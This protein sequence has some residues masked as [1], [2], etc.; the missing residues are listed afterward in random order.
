MHSKRL[1]FVRGAA[2]VIVLGGLLAILY[3]N[4]R[5]QPQYTPTEIIP[6]GDQALADNAVAPDAPLPTV[7]KAPIPDRPD[8]LRFPET[9]EAEIEALFESL[10]QAC[11]NSDLRMA[12]LIR[13]E[14]LAIYSEPVYLG[15]ERRLKELRSGGEPRVGAVALTANLMYLIA[16]TD[17][18]PVLEWL[19]QRWR[20][21]ELSSILRR[22]W[23]RIKDVEEGALASDV[24]PPE[25]RLE[26]AAVGHILGRLIG[27]ADTSPSRVLELV[28]GLYGN[29]LPE[30]EVP[31]PW[32]SH[33]LTEAMRKNLALTDD[34]DSGMRSFLTDLATNYSLS[35]CLRAQASLYLAGRSQTFAELLRAIGSAGSKKVVGK[36]IGHFLT[37]HPMTEEEFALIFAALRDKYGDY[38]NDMTEV[39]RAILDN[40]AHAEAVDT[41]HLVTSHLLEYITNDTTEPGLQWSAH[42]FLEGL[43][44]VW[45]YFESRLGTPVVLFG[46][47]SERDLGAL[48]A[49]VYRRSR[50][51]TG[52]VAGPISGIF[53]ASRALHLVWAAP[54]PVEE[55]MDLTLDLLGDQPQISRPDFN[56]ALYGLRRSIDEL[57]VQHYSRV[58]TIIELLYS[59]CDDALPAELAK[60]QLSGVASCLAATAD[61]L[62]HCKFPEL[63]LEVR[64][65]I[66]RPIDEVLAA[67]S[68][69]EIYLNTSGREV[70]SLMFDN[71][72]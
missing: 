55:R 49:A 19:R 12:G 37:L 35:K 41:I 33:I 30:G 2:A 23:H 15:A 50:G 31:D 52:N 38:S 42:E 27:T 51:N 71:Y 18:A 4:N 65:R 5:D 70:L 56:A 72:R 6:C 20:D 44:Q 24:L 34:P 69:K 59:R 46:P 26:A 47:N 68:R 53:A 64:Q 11:A 32:L 3:L 36:E 60:G 67:S 63:N 25:D 22:R 57:D 61:L 48:L 8:E 9:S 58:G 21:S 66:T 10:V 16:V 54:L 29:S 62:C 40:I 1:W 14:L 28:H 7:E 17:P 45:P 13:S 43:R 39:A